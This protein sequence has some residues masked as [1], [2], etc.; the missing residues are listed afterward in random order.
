M[1]ILSF[2][3]GL[4]LTGIA[5][6]VAGAVVAPT[7]WKVVLS[8]I[9]GALFGTSLSGIVGALSSRAFGERLIAVLKSSLAASFSAPEVALQPYR[10]WAAGTFGAS[11][12]STSET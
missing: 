12:F 6:I 9:G 2:L 7:F 10:K 5:L 4:G 3:A 8:A 11:R 1:P